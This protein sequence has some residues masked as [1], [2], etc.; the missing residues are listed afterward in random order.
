MSDPAH[1]TAPLGPS[2]LILLAVA[3]GASVANSYYNQAMLGH[4]AR[5]F[6]LSGAAVAAI[7]VLTQ[8]GNALG[9]LLL[10]PL[11]DRVERRLL[12]LITLSLLVAALLAAAVAPSFIVL[13]I[14]SFA[15]GGFATVAQQIVPLAV[16]IAPATERGSVLGKVTGGIL[17]GILLARAV[18]GILSD[19]WSWRI[20]FL[21]AAGLMMLI[22]TLLAWR[23]P[24]VRPTTDLG[25]L[26][27]IASLGQ[28]V[29]EHRTLRRATLMQCLLFAA[30]IGFWSTLALELQSPSFG[31][32]ST[33]VGLLALIGVAGA[34]AAPLAGRLADRRGARNVAAIG[35]LM[36]AA[37]FTLLGAFQGSIAA[38]ILATLG[39]D[40]AI[41]SSQIANQTVVYAI[42]PAAR[43]RLNTIFMGA[44]L[45]SGATGAAIS[46]AAYAAWGWTGVCI[47]GGLSAL[48][49]SALALRRP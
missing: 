10:A 12:I 33:S 22:G 13:M 43:S 14:A 38:L 36:V 8:L 29:R 17:I 7:P 41:Q 44:M 23:L 24:K 25:Y 2:L 15:V 6:A 47:F 16:H 32:G 48:L 11:G 18:S 9:V 37:A 40:L 45:L 30:F 4:M 3:A 46:G 31:L 1:P 34:M 42:D 19:F 39:L 27:L 28:L 21:F 20:A 35:A 49:A 5:D 26:R